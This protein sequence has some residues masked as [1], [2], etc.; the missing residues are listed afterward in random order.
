MEFAIAAHGLQKRFGDK[1]AV[2]GVDLIARPGE[3]LGFL[4]QNGAGKTT[5]IRMLLGILTPDGGTVE[6]LGSRQPLTVAGRIGYL[7]EE[8]GLYPAMT[9]RETIA[10]MGALR[11]LPLAEGRRRAEALLARHG[12]KAEIGAKIR[13]LSKGMAQ[14]VQ[15]LGSFVHGPD[16]IILDEPFSGLDPVNQQALERIIAGER[17]RGATILFSTHIMSHAERLCD[18]LVIVGAGRTRFTGTV[19]EARAVLPAQVVLKTGHPLNGPLAGMPAASA[20]AADGTYRFALPEEGLE[21]I[22]RHLL[23]SGASIREIS[24]E[25]PDLHDVFVAMVGDPDEEDG[26]HVGAPMAEVAP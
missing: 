26:A 20:Q 13:T 12:L 10:F 21:P 9:T 4:G 15:L 11:G 18:N 8:R 16:L 3:I 14:K 23:D 17:A 19:A 6:V 7:P 2:A 5:T 24:V 22:L 1:L 25:R